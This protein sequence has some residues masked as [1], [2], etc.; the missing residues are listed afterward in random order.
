MLPWTIAKAHGAL[1]AALPGLLRQR[2][3]I[4]RLQAISAKEFKQRLKSHL[5]SAKEVAEQ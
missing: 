3:Q 2:S 4:L 1:I 5:I